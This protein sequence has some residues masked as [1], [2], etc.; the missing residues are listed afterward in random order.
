MSVYS[1]GLG[2]PFVLAG[3]GVSKLTGTLGWL[4]RHVRAVNL[5]SGVLL[6]IVGLLF[7][8]ERL[9]VISS[10]MQRSFTALNLD[11]WSSF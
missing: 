2:V 10:W 7:L 5:A 1:L 8:T 6:V 3:L 11:F 4:R 9:F